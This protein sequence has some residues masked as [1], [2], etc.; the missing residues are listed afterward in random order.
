M[1]EIAIGLGY[2]QVLEVD[3]ASA[4]EQNEQRQAVAE[5]FGSTEE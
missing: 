2:E 5:E 1:Q 3:M 4:L